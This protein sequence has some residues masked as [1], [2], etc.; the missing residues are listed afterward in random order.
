[1]K[2]V[3]FWSA[4]SMIGLILAG[5]LV[6]GTGLAWGAQQQQQPGSS[7]G[8][9]VIQEL[10]EPEHVRVAIAQADAGA[11][12]AMAISFAAALTVALSCL[13]AGYA[14]A[15][16]GAAAMGAAAEKPELLGRALIFVGLAEGIAIYGLIV[17]VLLILQL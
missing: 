3:Q 9:A 16:I 11:R 5:L 15:K 14:V 13:A 7:A 17:G 1:M 10:A 4:A 6:L 2:N 12:R 8:E